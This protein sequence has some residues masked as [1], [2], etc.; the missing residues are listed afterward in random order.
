MKAA[1]GDKFV[2]FSGT[3]LTFSEGLIGK[4]LKCFLNKATFSAFIFVKRHIL[5]NLL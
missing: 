5:A 1:L 3:M 4:L 2:Q